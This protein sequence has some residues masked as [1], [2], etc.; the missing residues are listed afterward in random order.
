MLLTEWNTEEAIAVRYEEGC[1]KGREE[2]YRTIAM[3][4]LAEGASPE[5]VH[6]ITGLDMEII[7]RLN[8]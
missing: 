2:S 5:F 8:Q 3:N 4:A 1:K 6:K 7:Q